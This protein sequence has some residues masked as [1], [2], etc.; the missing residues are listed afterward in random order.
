MYGFRDVNETS[1]SVILPSEAMQ[2]NGEYIENLVEGYRTL[3]V[4]GREALSPEIDT[5]ETGIRDGAQIKNKRYPTRTIIVKYQL[6]AADN[7]AFRAAY[8][9]L[10]RILDLKEAQ[11]IF[12]DEQDKYFIGTPSALGEVEPGRNAVVGEIEFFCA[13]PFKYSVFEYE[14]EASLDDNSI[15]LDYEGTYKSYPT[16]EADFY[17][18]TEVADDG[19]T[20]G[21]LTG[22]G[23]CGYVAFFTEDK[24]IVQLGDPEE[25]DGYNNIPKS[26]T[27]TNQTFLS[28]TSWGTTAK[29]LWSVNN[30]PISSELSQVGNVA[31]GVAVAPTYETTTT[32]SAGTTSRTLLSVITGGTEAKM[33]YTVI[34]KTYSR[35]GTRV[36]VKFS[37]TTKILSGYLTSGRGLEARI[38]VGGSWHSVAMK[39]KNV[40]ER[41]EANTAHTKNLTVTVSG[42]NASTTAIS[43]IR[44]MVNRTDT[45]GNSG[46]LP[47]TAC[48]DMPVSM[49]VTSSSTSEVSGAEYYLAPSSYGSGSGE[50]GVAI[51]RTISA[52]ASGVVGAS[53]FTFTYKQKLCYANTYSGAGQQGSFRAVLSDASGKEVASILLYKA[54]TGKHANLCYYVN[55]VLKST[56]QV[57]IYPGNTFFGGSEGQGWLNIIKKV[58]ASVF[59][60]VGDFNRTFVDESITD[61]QVTQITFYFGQYGTK[62][63]LAYNGL[64]WAKFVK[65]NCNTWREIPNKFSANDKVSADCRTGKIYLNGVHTPGLGALGNDWEDFY[66]TPGLNQIGFSYSDWV[67]EGYEPTIRIKW[68]EVFL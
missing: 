3:S 10:G 23:D 1:D 15:L 37:I 11:L 32:G 45:N 35:T 54:W 9:Q 31:M 44:F 65:N 12:N 36:K 39:G 26:Q 40:A 61:T 14:A 55:G 22:A 5:F 33:S 25:V 47:S 60:A 46:E 58:G 66:L 2:I 48:K 29:S 52:D 38:Y 18:E 34:G 56:T 7:D 50:H 8:N 28:S 63:P 53:N 6:I 51:T 67:Q 49:Y 64:Y 62:T 13:D 16:L 27:L 17:Q 24:K 68:R 59:F 57:D 43:G 30:A 19:E 4:S 41:W 21:E 20:A 42:L